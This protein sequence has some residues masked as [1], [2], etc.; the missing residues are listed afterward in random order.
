M[1]RTH[2]TRLAAG[3][4]AAVIALTGVGLP[5]AVAAPSPYSLSG[6]V[7]LGPDHTPATA[8]EVQVTLVNTN[9]VHAYD[10]SGAT[11]ADR[12]FGST[13]CWAATARSRAR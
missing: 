2:L 1:H 7:L 11:A 5:A 3:V 8:G 4:A 6:R 9:E 13:S 10:R 12:S